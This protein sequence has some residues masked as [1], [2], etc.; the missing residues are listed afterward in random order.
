MSN[1]APP[2]L[3]GPE[4]QGM[5]TSSLVLGILSVMCFGLFA[6]I[7]AIILGH[8]AHRRARRMP[9]KYAGS[10]LAIAGFVMGYVSLITT[11]ILAGMLLPA[12]AKA[13]GR[14][15]SIAC[16]NNMKQLGLAL[17]IYANDHGDQFP[18]NVSTN[19][20]SPVKTR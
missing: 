1:D 10:G 12:L 17:R 20:S 8:T 6:G 19:E 14:A 3:P 5:A 2:P 9:A 13:K 16:M 18:F 7:P 4:S 15:Q 11:F